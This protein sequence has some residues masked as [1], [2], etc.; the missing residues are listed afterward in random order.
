MTAGAQRYP[1]WPTLLAVAQSFPAQPAL[2]VAEP[3]STSSGLRVAI[4]TS[5]PEFS[6]G[7]IAGHDPFDKG[8]ICVAIRQHVQI[9]D[10][11]PSAIAARG[12][13]LA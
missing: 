10:V 12:P 3:H 2:P 6:V 4:E 8:E 5:F 1:A 11:R 13:Y 9:I 7:W